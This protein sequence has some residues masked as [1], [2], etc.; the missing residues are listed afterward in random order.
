MPINNRIFGSDIPIK[1]KKTLE[2]RQL[3]AEKTRLPGEQINPSKYPDDREDYYNYGELLDNQF[4]GVA[5]L[6]SRT[7]F[8]RMWTGVQTGVYE[9]E[10][11]IVLYEGKKIEGFKYTGTAEDIEQRLKDIEEESEKAQAHKDQKSTTFPKSQ[12]SFKKDPNDSTTGKFVVK[13]PA[14][15]INFSKP[16]VYMLGNHVLNTTDQITPQQQITADEYQTK[17]SD[18]QKDYITGEM[19]PDEHG[20]RN[21]VNKFLKP[22]AGIVSVSSETEGAL[23]ERKTT[24]INFVVHNFADFDTIYNRYFLR[25]GAQV[26]IDFGWS[27]V[28]DLYDPYEIIGTNSE[29]GKEAEAIMIEKLYGEKQSGDSQDGVVTRSKGNLEVLIG[30]V[31]NYDS[32]ILENGSVEC[33]LTI[34]SPNVAMMTFPKLNHLKTKID[35]LLD[36]FFGFEAIKNFGTHIDTNPDSPTYGKVISKPEFGEVPDASSSAREIADFEELVYKK[37]SESFGGTDFNPT[38][39]AGIAG[40]FLPGGEQSDAQYTSIGFLE[41]KILNAEFAFGKNIDEINDVKIKGL[42]T[43]MDS[44]ESFTFYNSEFH[45]RQAIIGNTGEPDPAFLI[46]RFWDRTYNTITEHI[47]FRNVNLEDKI[48]TFNT[49]FDNWIATD[50]E[51]IG[52][53]ISY[54]SEY[55]DEAPITDYDK[56]INGGDENSLG[57]IPIR[58]IFIHNDIIKEAFGAESKSFKDIVNHI[59]NAINEDSYGVFKLG[60]AGGQDNTLKIID[61][62]YLGIDNTIQDDAFDKLFTFD[63]MSPS[64]IVKNYNVN[65]SLPNDAIGANVAIQALGGTNEQV[66]P[67]NEAIANAASLAEIFKVALKD[68]DLSVIGA[69]QEDIKLKYLPDIGGFRGKNLSDSNAEKVTYENLYKTELTEAND[70]YLNVGYSNIID[71]ENPLQ[72]KDEEGENE[73]NDE[74][75]DEKG[76]NTRIIDAIDNQMAQEGFLVTKTFQ[77]YFRARIGDNFTFKKNPPLPL[78]LEL[79]TYGISSLVP[80]DV[81]RVDYL[82]KIYRDTCYFQVTK[83]KHNVGS[84]GWYTTLETVFRYREV[85]STAHPIKGRYRG[86]AVSAH[87]FD[88]FKI[89]DSQAYKNGYKT[90]VVSSGYGALSHGLMGSQRPG[91]KKRQKNEGYRMQPFDVEMIQVGDVHDEMESLKNKTEIIL[92]DMHISRI[93]NNYAGGFEGAEHTLTEGSKVTVIQNFAQAPSYMR[94]I[95]PIGV[96]SSSS[97]IS[98]IFKFTV[99][100]PEGQGVI[101]ISP[102]Y[103]SNVAFDD[104]YDF[105]DGYGGKGF[106]SETTG[107]YVDGDEVFLIIS[108]QGTQYYGYVPCAKFN[109]DK[110]YQSQGLMQYYNYGPKDYTS[111]NTP[112]FINDFANVP[113]SPDQHAILTG[114]WTK[115]RL[116]KRL[117]NQEG[118]DN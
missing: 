66:L 42:E 9:G 57:R 19:F 83:V 37:A 39:L 100:V 92:T 24:T 64:S 118:Y 115:E 47:P 56:K 22:A 31:T 91:Y 75:G 12:V 7:P 16:K 96:P 104:T 50:L 74:S 98:M 53:D 44:S 101:F 97:E 71:T 55:P 28:K 21:D 114:N 10:D 87:I 102:M 35:F 82:P 40:L 67:V 103:W 27:S 15:N 116:T 79:T 26:F 106:P 5:D 76:K 86:F 2:A 77:E 59:L 94:N 54:F 36:H 52:D 99:E 4:N 117:K 70:F 20:V 51:V 105:H 73:S 63:I 17:S 85:K 18:E 113:A 93:N 58:E 108:K 81:F 61:E 48:N 13:R 88:E 6:S 62:N 68:T 33:S 78:K 60:L 34:Q 38:V 112:D 43:K 72:Q 109:Q 46:P 65:L 11:D 84:D 90:F 111:I 110:V 14:K 30:Q 3:A 23:G 107:F 69:S 95:T 80:G 32:K 41:D 89:D 1:V 49:K 29:D 25:P 45:E 8:I